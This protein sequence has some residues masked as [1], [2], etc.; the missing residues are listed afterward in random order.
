MVEETQ[1]TLTSS[2]R[3]QGRTQKQTARVSIRQDLP[4]TC[5]HPRAPQDL[6]YHPTERRSSTRERKRKKKTG[7]RCEACRTQPHRQDEKT[8]HRDITLMV[9]TDCD[10]S[11]QDLRD[12]FIPTAVP[13]YCVSH[14]LSEIRLS[15]WISSNSFKNVI[16]IPLIW[17][18]DVNS[19]Q[20]IWHT[21]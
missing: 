19:D 16:S 12:G 14:K 17:D 2:T 3:K 4:T 9:M 13:A 6:P 18:E 1:V 10:V 15:T 21:L 20:N 5:R 7:H 8:I 11:G